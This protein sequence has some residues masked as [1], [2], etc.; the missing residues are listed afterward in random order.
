[1]RNAARKLGLWAAV[2]AVVAGFWLVG[3][4]RQSPEDAIDPLAFRIDFVEERIHVSVD[5]DAW[6]PPD[7]AAPPPSGESRTKR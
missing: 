3:A 6:P 1:M 5:L 2:I 4:S 7:V